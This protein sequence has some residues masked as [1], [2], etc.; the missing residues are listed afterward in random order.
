MNLVDKVLSRKPNPADFTQMMIRAFQKAGIPEVE[1]SGSDFSLKLEGGG[2]IFLSNI[3]SNYC[4]ARRGARQSVVS[5]FV[6]AAVS[7]AKEPAIPTDFALVK[8]SLMPTIRDAANF[9]LMQLMNRKDGKSDA[10][11]DA[12]TKPLAE[13]LVVELA[14]DTERNITSINRNMLEPWGVSADEAF[15]T[16]RENLWE[17]TNPNRLAGQGGVYR[18]EWADAYDSSR[19][20]LTELIYRLSVDGDPVAFVPNRDQFWVTGTDNQAGLGAILKGGAESHFK[21]G[22]PI[23]PDLY[24]LVDGAWKVYVPEDATLRELSLSIKRG[25]AEIDYSQQQKVLNEVHEKEEIDVFVSS[26]KVYELNGT[27]YSA[28][29]WPIDVDSSLPRAEKIAFLLDEHGKDAFMV[30]WKAA[31]SVVGDLLEEEAGL[32]PVRY[33]ARVFPSAERIGKLRQLAG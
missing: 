28:C 22:H 10:G 19:I 23:S 26:Y 13:G 11:L 25:R 29:V 24:R 3:Y 18:G 30:P 14:Y 33:R 31:T 16:A 9:G 5:E 21:Q 1:Q 27:T 32:T 2:T 15:K 17:K 6:A 12:L 4:H 8:Q 7:I 20:L